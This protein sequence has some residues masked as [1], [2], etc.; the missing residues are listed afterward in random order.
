[1]HQFHKFILS[2]NSTYFGQ[3]LCP[4]SGVNSLYTRQWYMSYRFV[5]SFRTGP[6]W[7]CSSILVL[8]ESCLQTCMT[9]PLPSEQWMNSWWWAEELSETCRVSCQNKLVKLVHLVGFIIKKSAIHMFNSVPI[10]LF[11]NCTTMFFERRCEDVNRS[12]PAQVSGV[13][14]SYPI[15]PECVNFSFCVS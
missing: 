4:P 6:G 7:N 15:A 10:I 12:Q 2:W 9:H 14:P 8:L 5:D 11:Y 3:F 13:E 1:M